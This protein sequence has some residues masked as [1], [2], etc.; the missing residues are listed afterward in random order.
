[1]LREAEGGDWKFPRM[2]ESERSWD[3]FEMLF[4]RKKKNERVDVVDLKM[5]S[6]VYISTSIS[7]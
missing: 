4:L 1:M 7:S 2:N 3:A 5:D 6:D